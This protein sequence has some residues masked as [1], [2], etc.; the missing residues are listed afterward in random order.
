M[1]FSILPI[2]SAVKGTIPETPPDVILPP[3]NVAFTTVLA[4]KLATSPIPLPETEQETVLAEDVIN[5]EEDVEI[6]I[7][8]D[9]EIAPDE[10]A[11]EKTDKK[12]EVPERHQPTL[13]ESTFGPVIAVSSP[14]RPS[15]EQVPIVPSP[16]LSKAPEPQ[17]TDGRVIPMQ[18][19]GVVEKD[20]APARAQ[21][22]IRPTATMPQ[23]RDHAEKVVP[24]EPQIKEFKTATA[25]LDTKP[26]AP[27]HNLRNLPSQ[28]AT[29]T[30]EPKA[31]ATVPM[32][33]TSVPVKQPLVQEEPKETRREQAPVSVAPTVRS[34]V[35]TQI[36]AAT[37]APMT[38]PPQL[39]MAAPFG[40]QSTAADLALFENLKDVPL[41]QGA[42]DVQ[43]SSPRISGPEATPLP[44]Q[45]QYIAKSAA[46]QMAVAVSQSSGGATEITLSPEELGRVRMVMTAQDNGITVLI[47][48]ERPET[49]DLL[50]RHIDAL[51][52]EFKNMGYSTASFTFAQDQQD[53]STQDRQTGRAAVQEQPLDPSDTPTPHN[54]L[55]SAGLDLRL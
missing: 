13:V 44:T 46:H 45:Q 17:P 54:H 39:A 41:V 30:P 49:N 24:L 8:T 25:M 20:L 53:G 11:V 14:P 47:H 42:T 51:S 36:P 23:M 38:P 26:E 33:L 27:P 19:T 31:M 22:I 18:T 50:R 29:L 35:E 10:S 7:K 3:E 28:P 2:L 1:T 5:T 16:N 12:P 32:P 15:L 34:A 40:M 55:A 37:V 52:Q 48:A 9:E 6:A 21:D 43:S 4:N